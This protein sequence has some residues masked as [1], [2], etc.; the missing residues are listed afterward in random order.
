[1]N[2]LTVCIKQAF[3]LSWVQLLIF[4]ER[5]E[6]PYEVNGRVGRDGKKAYSGV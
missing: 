3:H 6:G 4:S 2:R 1:M 5:S